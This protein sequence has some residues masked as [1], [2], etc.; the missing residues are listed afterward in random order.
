MTAAATT[1]RSMRWRELPT[2]PRGGGPSMGDKLPTIPK[3]GQP[4]L[5]ID[6]LRCELAALES[7]S[8]T[9]MSDDQLRDHIGLLHDGFNITRPIYPPGQMIC[10]AVRVTE[11]PRHKARLSC[12]PVNRVLVNGRLNRAGQVMFYGTFGGYEVCLRES[13][14]AAGDLF[15]VSVWKT[16]GPLMLHHFGYSKEVFTETKTERETPIWAQHVADNER[17]A[18]LRAWQ[19]RVF[20]QSIADGQEHLYRL[21][22]A[23]TDLALQHLRRTRSTKFFGAPVCAR[24]GLLFMRCQSCQSREVSQQ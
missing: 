5:S 6:E 1:W 10:R 14:C 16:T 11:K 21:S 13:R 7:G 19:A 9:S 4:L 2:D 18:L 24:S 22:I 20:T 23:L 17:N 8:F 3:D 15:A 12:P